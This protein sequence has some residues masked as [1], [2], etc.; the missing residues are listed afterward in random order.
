MH[1]HKLCKVPNVLTKYVFISQTCINVQ[2]FLFIFIL[3][4][5]LNYQDGCFILYWRTVCHSTRST[6]V[7]LPDSNF[8]IS[9]KNKCYFSHEQQHN[10]CKELV[11][12]FVST[13][14]RLKS[15]T[16]LRYTNLFG[17]EVNVYTDLDSG[18]CQAQFVIVWHIFLEKLFSVGEAG[19]RFM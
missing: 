6:K 12:N 19:A 9:H 2:P 18:F 7:L 1:A 8:Y 5:M 16:Y 15:T 14:R 17:S 10:N 11:K 3:Y 13:V 4:H